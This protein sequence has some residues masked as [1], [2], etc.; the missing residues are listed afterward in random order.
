MSG[1]FVLV[2]ANPVSVG[3]VADAVRHRRF[4][5]LC[6]RLR[7][8]LL[9]FTFWLSRDRA[10]AED[11]VQETLLRAWNAFDSLVDDRAA[12]SWLLTIARRELAR[13]Y[14]RD[15]R[16]TVDIDELIVVD[17][18]ALAA[19]EEP[20]LEDLRREVLALA[21]IYREPLLLQVL[22]GYSTLEIASI[23]GIKRGTVLTRLHR[24]REQLRLAL[25]EGAILDDERSQND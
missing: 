11:V 15:P 5:A 19:P 13:I 25:G 8:D 21:D 17:H 20:D 7:N 4:E 18:P 1:K 14:G 24:A 3:S 9:R 2:A 12:R 23:M 10:L 16:S 6:G 22:F